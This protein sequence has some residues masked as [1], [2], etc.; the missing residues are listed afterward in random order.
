MIIFPLSPTSVTICAPCLLNSTTPNCWQS[1]ATLMK[2]L[3]K[4]STFWTP[5]SGPRSPSSTI[6]SRCPLATDT[7]PFPG[8]ALPSATSGGTNELLAPLSRIALG[9]PVRTSGSTCQRL[10]LPLTAH[11][12]VHQHLEHAD[13][14]RRAPAARRKS[15]SA[16]A[17]VASARR[18]RRS[19]RAPRPVARRY[20][21]ARRPPELSGGKGRRRRVG[22]V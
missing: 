9:R 16:R 7:C 13:L 17:G 15:T 10:P 8:L 21:K 18:R 22:E 4:L 3:W 12:E 11:H 6:A 5:R 14:G 1:C 20:A 2:T 19:A